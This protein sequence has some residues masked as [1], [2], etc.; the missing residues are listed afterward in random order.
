MKTQISLHVSAEWSESFLF[1]SEIYWTEKIWMIKKFDQI[2]VM[3][4]W[5]EPSLRHVQKCMFS[6]SQSYCENVGL[7]Q[8]IRLRQ[9]CRSKV[10]LSEIITVQ[11]LRRRLLV[12]SYQSCKRACQR[13]MRSYTVITNGEIFLM[14]KN[15][16]YYS[17]Y[18][19]IAIVA[20]YIKPK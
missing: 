9:W 13:G 15:I 12:S 18:H 14:M 17:H 8:C 19:I 11:E 4:C 16:K 20:W 2:M 1:V 3:H 7:T 5:S 6:M 10:Q